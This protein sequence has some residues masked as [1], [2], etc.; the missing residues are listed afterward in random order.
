MKKILICAALILALALCACGK[1]EIHGIAD[2]GSDTAA[3]TRGIEFETTDLD[4]NTVSSEELF[5]AHKYTMVNVWTTWCTYCVREMPELQEMS[6]ALA[7]QDCAVVGIL[8]DSADAG[9]VDAAKEIMELAGADFLVLQ[10][11]E[12][13]DALFPVQG[14]PTTFFVDSEGSLVGKEV[15]GADIARYQA[16]MDALLADES[17]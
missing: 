16:Q 14:F 3:Q 7:E 13:V 9:A 6:E 2:N 11:P 17:A 15:V 10:A 8:Y 4:G 1:T 12:N 5:A